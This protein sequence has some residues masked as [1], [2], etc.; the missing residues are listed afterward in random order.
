M[1]KDEVIDKIN[2]CLRYQ[3]NFKWQDKKNYNGTGMT[4]FE[5]HVKHHPIDEEKTGK[6]KPLKLIDYK[7]YETISESYFKTSLDLAKK[8][9]LL[10]G[11]RY[12]LQYNENHCSTNMVDMETGLITCL[13]YDEET[14]AFDIATCFFPNKLYKFYSIKNKV[15]SAMYQDREFDIGFI[16]NME[17]AEIL[18]NES[19]YF[20]SALIEYFKEDSEEC[21][22]LFNNESNEEIIK[23]NAKEVHDYLAYME[24]NNINSDAKKEYNFIF[25]DAIEYVAKMCV[26][27]KSIKNT[28]NNLYDS[29][30]NRFMRIDVNNSLKNALQKSEEILEK[31]RKKQ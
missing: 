5:Y 17:K 10:L 30:Y 11:K 7:N 4:S 18:N 13:K 15:F 2:L 14:I 16:P 19:N 25:S 8:F 23:K 26:L 21:K 9:N 1:T 29:L 28:N 27:Y 31:G 12:D 6:W 24:N 3:T 20:K 22:I